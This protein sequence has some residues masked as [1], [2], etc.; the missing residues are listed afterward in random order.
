METVDTTEACKARVD[1]FIIITMPLMHI[2]PLCFKMK[3][4]RFETAVRGLQLVDAACDEDGPPV[5]WSERLM[6]EKMA[7]RGLIMRQDKYA[8]APK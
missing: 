5:V 3:N 4:S 6:R 8:S 2:D 1:F 7:S